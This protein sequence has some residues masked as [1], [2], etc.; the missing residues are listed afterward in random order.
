MPTKELQWILPKKNG[1]IFESKIFY[2]ND[3]FYFTDSEVKILIKVTGFKMSVQP[4]A[5][6]NP[7]GIIFQP[8]DYKLTSWTSKEIILQGSDLLKL[9]SAANPDDFTFIHGN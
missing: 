3:C 4:T 7:L 5:E 1:V 8:W 2:I 9:Q 6:T